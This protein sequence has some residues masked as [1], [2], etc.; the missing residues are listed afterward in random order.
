M[1]TV[2]GAALFELARR[3]FAQQWGQVQEEI[4][5]VQRRAEGH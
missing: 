1:L 2:T 3:Q 5:L 4:E